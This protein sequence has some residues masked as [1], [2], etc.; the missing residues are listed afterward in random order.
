MLI[1]ICCCIDCAGCRDDVGDMY[2]D[3]CCADICG[4]CG[5][6][7]WCGGDGYGLKGGEEREKILEKGCGVTGGG[8]ARK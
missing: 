2:C 4:E 8:M 5:G 1:I 3:K 7:R 6:E